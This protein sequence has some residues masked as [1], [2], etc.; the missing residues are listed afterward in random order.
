M[1]RK[2]RG[3]TFIELILV[4]AILAIIGSFTPILYTNFFSQNAAANTVDQFAGSLRKA[5][6]YAMMGRQND[7]W[8]VSFTTSPKTI[9]L[10][11]GSSFASR[12][13]AFDETFSVDDATTITFSTPSTDVNF[14][15]RTGVPSIQPVITITNGTNIKTVTV[16]SQGV[17]SK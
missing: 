14:A 10:Y 2:L 15:R 5:Q 3:F 16:N 4:V 11:R 8:G 9:T 13:P 17:V 6:M 7:N 12:L 1:R